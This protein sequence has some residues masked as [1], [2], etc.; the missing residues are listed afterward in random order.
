MDDK[1]YA[2]G[3]I[4]GLNI[5]KFEVQVKLKKSCDPKGIIISKYDVWDKINGEYQKI[6]DDKIE[7][8]RK[9]ETRW[10]SYELWDVVK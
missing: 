7:I 8:M 2:T 1:C 4:V 6:E 5:E 9:G 3:I 10:T